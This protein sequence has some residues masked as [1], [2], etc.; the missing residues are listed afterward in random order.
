MPLISKKTKD[1]IREQILAYLFSQAP[2]AKYTVEVATHL[3]RDEE[4]VKSLLSDLEE[5]SLVVKITKSPQ[6]TP[7]SRRQRWRLSNAAF[8]AYKRI[9]R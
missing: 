1:R 5:S 6:G 3:A 2:E 4:F 7:F 8:D 9:Q